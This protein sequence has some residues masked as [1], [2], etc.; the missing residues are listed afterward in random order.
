MKMYMAGVDHDSDYGWT[1]VSRTAKQS[2]VG[3][4]LAEMACLRDIIGGPL[5]RISGL[6][7]S[8]LP[9]YVQ[10]PSCGID[11]LS[12][13]LTLEKKDTVVG[14]IFEK[15]LNCSCPKPSKRLE[16]KRNNA[17]AMPLS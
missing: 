13:K 3:W 4:P 1:G 5:S 16:S 7:N 8:L 6:H 2:K 9:V 10:F 14:R 15:Q 12:E 11:S 17:I